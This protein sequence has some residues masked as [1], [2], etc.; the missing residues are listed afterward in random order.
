MQLTL[1]IK[2]YFIYR[3]NLCDLTIIEGKKYFTTPL[4]TVIDLSGDAEVQY[5]DTGHLHPS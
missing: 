5:V 4:S 3:F 1:S 2:V